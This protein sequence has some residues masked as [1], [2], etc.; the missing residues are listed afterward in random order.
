M[1]KVGN[2]GISDKRGFRYTCYVAIA[3]QNLKDFHNF[4]LWTCSHI[5]DMSR[6]QNKNDDF[7]RFWSDCVAL[8]CG[9][10]GGLNITLPKY[11]NFK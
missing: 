3:T 9:Y 5:M 4:N 2:T 10:T 1:S 8:I 6:G 11:D 7:S